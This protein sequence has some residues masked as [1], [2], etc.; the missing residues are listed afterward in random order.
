MSK[1]GA[2]DESCL[3]WAVAFLLLAPSVFVV[4]MMLVFC[5]IGRCPGYGPTLGS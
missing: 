4:A 5:S 1:Q 2:L 3:F